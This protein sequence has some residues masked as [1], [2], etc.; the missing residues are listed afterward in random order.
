MLFGSK[1]KLIIVFLLILSAGLVY[2][3][4]NINSNKVSSSKNIFGEVLKQ[5]LI[6]RVTIA[7]AV[8]PIRKTIIT[9]PYNGYV[10]KLF[11]TIGE[12][13]KIGDSLVSVVQ[14]LQSN[15]NIFPLRS[16]LNGTVVQIAKN[17]GE[18]V[19]VE[20]PKE[21]ILRI[22]DLSKLFILANVPEIDRVKLKAGQEVIIKASAILNKTYKGIIRELS[23][24]AK[25]KDQWSRSQVVEFPIKIEITERDEN[26]KPGMSVVIDVITERKD[27]ILTLRHEYIQRENENY[28]VILADG[29]RKDIKVGIQ[30]EDGFEILSGLK[31]GEKI[32]LV[33]FANINSSEN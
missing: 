8:M 4:Y 29:S 26:I 16:P 33:D 22:D 14:S 1:K 10:K 25:E 17:E 9:A 7:G 6:Q 23:L 3:F 11:V 21:F 30:N 13:V 20:D 24:A 5:N 27:N 28:Y 15:D 32:K 2:F 19:R 12:Q 31:E 18:F